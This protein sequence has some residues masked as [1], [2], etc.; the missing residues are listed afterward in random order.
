MQ[1]H[2]HALLMDALK[3]EKGDGPQKQWAGTE[4]HWI[5]KQYFFL[6]LLAASRALTDPTQLT[7]S[8]FGKRDDNPHLG[9]LVRKQISEKINIQ[10]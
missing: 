1:M 10:G 5:R 8:R 3:C 4:W 6:S 2:T 7:I 9:D